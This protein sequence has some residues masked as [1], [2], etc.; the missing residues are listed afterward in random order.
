MPTH[1]TLHVGG[2]VTSQ[3]RL[4]DAPFLSQ[5]NDS[6]P[7]SRSACPDD[8]T[9]QCEWWQLLAPGERPY[10]WTSGDTLATIPGI[11]GGPYAVEIAAR[12]QPGDAPTPSDW[13]IGTSLS[14]SVELPP[15]QMRR[16]RI[17]AP[18]D[19]SGDLHISMRTQPLDAPGDPRELGFVL[20]ELRAAQTGGGPRAPAWPQ[21]GWMALAI[22]AA[23][24]TQRALSVGPRLSA[25]LVI[26]MG[27]A[28]AIALALA[29]P[30]ITI[31]T[32]TLAGMGLA[33]VLIAAVAWAATHRLGTSTPFA[34]QV[35]ALTLLALALRV[36]GM[37]HPHA[38]YSDSRF[39]ANKLY[40]LSLGYV[41]QLAG[42]PSETGGGQAP[43]PTGAYML[44]LP[45][46]LLLDGDQR[47]ALVQVGTA[48]LDSLLVPMISLLIVRAGLGRR[49]ALLGAACYLLPITA[50]ESFAIGELANIGG[51]SIAMG[52]VAL[53]AGGRW[54]VT[55][56]RWQIAALATAALAAGLLAHSGVTLSL[57]AFTAAAWL[58]TLT[59]HILRRRS[60]TPNPQPPTPNPWLLTII[61]A[62][63]L[64]IALLIYYSA[65]IYMENILGRVGGAGEGNSGPRTGL[66]PLTIIG[67]TGAGVLGLIPPR[68]R[69]HALPPLLGTLALGGL[70]LLWARRREQPAAAG[71][72]ITLAALWLGALITQAI[73]LVADQGVR[74]SLFL[75]PA[76]CL[77]AGPLLDALYRRGRA[78]KTVALAALGSTFAYGM[79]IWIVQIRDYLH[80]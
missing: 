27:V 63:A 72:R 52:F 20:Y 14:I 33:S 6:E 26:A 24:A 38:I 2:D 47:V 18:T 68:A 21:I 73:L 46:Q 10:R 9:Q 3:R 11:G 25:A 56:G 70:G 53:L 67:E 60:P 22:A 31:F 48:L 65:P 55:G 50:L 19:P 36:G 80:T 34:R 71:L 62:A 75:Y 54:Q 61:A 76:L 74:W 57:G 43:Y 37:F 23:Y 5:I 30:E 69:P 32:P 51:Q 40:T 8:A 17:L 16:Y 77:S 13:Q 28:L 4:D 44:L 45:G 66:S 29:R 12:G 64:S 49:A 15:S 7:P 41:Y 58:I 79:L 35:I 39:H 42:L 78:G 59:Q 1:I